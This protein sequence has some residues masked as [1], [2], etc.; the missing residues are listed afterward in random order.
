MRFG[1]YDNKENCEEYNKGAINEG[2]Y[3]RAVCP[4]ELSTIYNKFKDKYETQKEEL[5]SNIENPTLNSSNPKSERYFWLN[6]YFIEGNLKHK[7]RRTNSSES[8]LRFSDPN[9]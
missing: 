2:T 5:Q 8:I 4:G 3:W 6:S 9:I 7:K 1:Y